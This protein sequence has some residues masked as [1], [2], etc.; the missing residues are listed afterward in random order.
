ML[1]HNMH[2]W[3]CVVPPRRRKY[4]PICWICLN[5]P[6]F[7][8]NIVFSLRVDRQAFIIVG[9]FDPEFSLLFFLPTKC[10]V[11]ICMHSG[12]GHCRNSCWMV[13]QSIYHTP[14][15]CFEQSVNRIGWCGT[16]NER[17]DGLIAFESQNC[18]SCVQSSVIYLSPQKLPACLLTGNTA[19]WVAS[20]LKH[21]YSCLKRSG[22]KD[23]GGR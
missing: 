19:L 23:E 9:C 17:W 15:E 8:H 10:P 7:I 5:F 11:K 16:C 18:R 4:L 6:K 20:T 14:V 22:K 3:R 13:Q 21:P 2:C 12:C 1:C